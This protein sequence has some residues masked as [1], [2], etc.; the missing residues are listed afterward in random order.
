MKKLFFKKE[1]EEMDYTII[2][3]IFDKINEF[4]TELVD[5]HCGLNNSIDD[6]GEYRIL[7]GKLNTLTTKFYGDKNLFEEILGDLQ[8][9]FERYGSILKNNALFAIFALIIP[10]IG[11][12]LGLTIE[13]VNLLYLKK[14]K[15]DL[16]FLEQ[17]SDEVETKFSIIQKN[18]EIRYDSLNK[19]LKEYADK[20]N[21]V[22]LDYEDDYTFYY[23]NQILTNYLEGY[24]IVIDDIDPKILL[25]IFF[26]DL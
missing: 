22:E 13:G 4:E 26:S 25:E 10:Y 9:R 11:F 17:Y 12:I 2:S 3:T 15:D 20:Q 18:I 19:K 14:V 6:L 1:K 24:D 21:R 8:R 5:I 16:K 23:A 7:Q